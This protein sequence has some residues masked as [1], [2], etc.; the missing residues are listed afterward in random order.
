MVGLVHLW[1]NN[2]FNGDTCFMMCQ[3][4]EQ[5]ATHDGIWVATLDIIWDAFH[6]II[7]NVGFHV[8]RE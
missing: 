2:K 4:K 7:R 1:L 6:S 3:C 5:I 8:S